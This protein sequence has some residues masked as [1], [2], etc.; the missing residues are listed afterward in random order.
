MNWLALLGSIIWA[1]TILRQKCYGGTMAEVMVR[2]YQDAGGY[3]LFGHT[4]SRDGLLRR[5]GYDADFWVVRT[6]RG[7]EILWQA[8]Y[9]AEGDEELM[10]VHPLSDGGWL[11]VG[12]TDS[13][14]LSHGKK[15]AFILR[16]D[17][18]GKVVWQRAMGGEG[19]DMALGAGL[20]RDGTLW[21]LGQIGSRDSVFHP[22]PYG[23]V[24]A[25]LLR[26][27]PE[28]EVVG[29][30]TFGG[31]ENDYLRFYIPFSP[32]T[33]WLIGASDSPDGHIQNPL[34]R[35]DIW[36]VEVD[37]SGRFR[38]SWN[39][40]GP[41]F[42]EPYSYVRHPEG[43]IWVAGTSFS[44]GAATYGRADGVI[45]R[46]DPTGVAEV[47]WSG[48]GS[49]DEGLNFL[50]Y[51]SSDDWLIA[52][53]SSSR[54]GLITNLSG[55]YDAWALRWERQRDSLVFCY[56]FGGK[57]VDSWV[58]LFPAEGGAYVGCG[59]TASPGEQLGIR[60]FGNAD[61][62]LV[63]WHPD[64]ITPSFPAIRAPTVIT[65]YL[66]TEK[67]GT[68][69]KILFRSSSGKIIDSVSVEG[70]GLFR[71]EVPD[72]VGLEIWLSVYAVGHVWKD[73]SI[74]L[75][76]SRENRLDIY[77]EKIRPNWRLPLFHIT[78]EKGSA[79]LLP[80]ATPQLE[81]LYRFLSE[82]PNIRIEIS[83]HTDGTSLAESEIQLSRSRAQAVRDFLVS[84][85][86]SRDRFTIVGYGKSR[87]IADNATLEGQRRN[88]RVEI[89][90]VN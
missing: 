21:I 58:A 59:T 29:H 5:Q 78:F 8:N 54:N 68:P 67:K 76:K 61:F 69:G 51:T 77:L 6:D 89:R 17:A 2:A 75:R 26:L 11:L 27:S 24:D 14:S 86:L 56:T 10:D 47:V 25:W 31:S 1:Q 79:K 4:R 19:N 13:K 15:D 12:W 65:G 35:T 45:W 73:F 46:I 34:G 37:K 48:G 87:P 74:R 72:T 52:G 84:R 66:L 30:A 39:F 36:L 32:D 81:A 18:L 28:G 82:N 33:V 38:R 60:T 85:G 53:M 49:G 50:S 90:I 40:G 9:G 22:V 43:D 80:E 83:G 3:W 63:W 88:R 64:S 16:I 41:D 62:W 20:H 42:E 7:G 70:A 44:A 57:D 23:G 71:W 55:L